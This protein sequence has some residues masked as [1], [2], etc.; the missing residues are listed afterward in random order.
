MNLSGDLGGPVASLWEGPCCKGL[1]GEILGLEFLFKFVGLADLDLD[2]FFADA[3]LK[4][5]FF[6]GFDESVKILN[7]DLLHR[8]GL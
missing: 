8:F 3:V 2:F 6:V 1:E 7:C 4:N 5:D